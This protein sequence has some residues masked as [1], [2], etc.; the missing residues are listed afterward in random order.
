MTIQCHRHSWPAHVPLRRPIGGLVQTPARP[1]VGCTGCCQAK[2]STMEGL[3]AARGPPRGHHQ[4][5]Q[6]GHH[7]PSLRSRRPDQSSTRGQRG[8]HRPSLRSLRPDQGHHQPRLPSLQALVAS[9]TPSLPPGGRRLR[10]LP[11]PQHLPVPL[12]PPLA[13]LAPCAAPKTALRR[14][15]PGA[16]FHAHSRAPDRAPTSCR[17]APRAAGS[18]PSRQGCPAPALIRP[19]SP[20]R[21]L[22]HRSLPAQLAMSPA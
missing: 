2:S 1:P 10:L 15:P 4:P 21:L 16:A 7:Q 3:T 9:S 12:P 20:Q 13:A 6:R 19:F 17:P 5:S 22:S 14:A 11:L 18:Q 8:H